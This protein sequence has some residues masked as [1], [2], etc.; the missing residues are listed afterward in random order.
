MRVRPL[1]EVNAKWSFEMEEMQLANAAKILNEKQQEI[2]GMETLVNQKV[3]ALGMQKSLF[4]LEVQKAQEN[5]LEC[6]DEME[7]LAATMRNRQETTENQLRQE[8]DQL[9]RYRSELLQEKGQI[10]AGDKDGLQALR[11]R[12]TELTSEFHDVQ[13]EKVRIQNVVNMEVDTIGRERRKAEMMQELAAQASSTS[14]VTELAVRQE[15]FDA[16]DKLRTFESGAWSRDSQ[17]D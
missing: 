4:H 17:L 8:S 5:Y 16:Q 9:S 15:L 12:S 13:Q 7:V 6:K 3:E 10:D 11:T 2:T 1:D 14:A